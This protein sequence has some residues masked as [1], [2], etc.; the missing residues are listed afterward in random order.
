MFVARHRCLGWNRLGFGL[1]I[2]WISLIT[3]ALAAEDPFAAGVRSTDPL[4]PLEQQQK[5]RLPPGFEIQLV[6]NE[7]AIHKPMNLA[8]DATGRLWVTTSI[9]Y[10]WAAPTNKP[11]RDRLMIFED[12]GPD[13]RARK[14]TQFADGLNIPI[15][16][17]PF[18]TADRR[19]KA[20]VWSIPN[21]WLL[22]DTD[23]DGKADKREVLYGP[24]DYTR[25]THGN[26][27]SFRRGFDGWLY[28]THGYNND[29]HVTARDGSHVDLNSGN[30]YRIR[31]DGSRIEQH[32]HGQ[33]NPFGSAFDPQGNLYTSDCH[34]A[35]IYQLISGG[36]YPSFGKPHDGLGYAPVLM[37]HAHGSTA[38]D[39][40]SY[41]SDEGWHAEYRDNIFIGN[42]MTSR[43]NR[44]RLERIGS[45]PKAIELPD[46][47]T[48]EDSWFR[49][50][51]TCLGP[52]GALYIADFY[53]RIIG[54]YEVPLTHPGRDRERG[55][56]WRV[57]YRGKDSKGLLRDPKL[58]DDLTGLIGELGSESLPRRILAM[59][60]IEDRFGAQ[61]LEPVRA[62]LARPLSATQHA[63]ALWM[64]HR[65][66]QLSVG[67]LERAVATEAVL[68]RIHALRVAT[69]V[70]YRASRKLGSSESLIAAATRM[71]QAGLKDPDPQVQRVASEALA[72]RPHVD[73]VRP[74]LDRLAA[75]PAADTHLVYTLRKAIRDHLLEPTIFQSIL[76]DGA[77]GEG[78]I[79]ALADVAL[80]VRSEAAGSFLLKH[81]GLLESHRGLLSAGLKHAAQFAP[82]SGLEAIAGFAKRQFSG[83]LDFQLDLFKS[84]EQGASQRSI[85]L[86]NSLRRWGTD[87][88]VQAL[89][90]S[91]DSVWYNTPLET[92]TD[93]AN[94]WTFQE[95]LCAD[96]QRV[97]LL[98]SHPLG[99]TLTGRLRSKAFAVPATLSFYLSG[100]DGEPDRAPN[101][102]NV[103]RLRE[104]ATGAV[105]AEAVPP[106]NDT[107]QK[108]VWDLKEQAGKQAVLE[109]VDGDP[110]DAWAWMAFGRFDPPVVELPSRSPGEIAKRQQ[111]AGELA[112]RLRLPVGSQIRQVAMGRE[113]DV[114]ARASAIRA[115]AVLDG[116]SAV[117]ELTPILQDAT[118]PLRLRDAVG[119]ALLG[120]DQESARALV[121]GA[122]K[123]VP[124]RVQNGWA[125]VLATSVS[126]SS[127]LLDAVGSGAVPA[128]ILVERA[129]RDRLSVGKSAA[130]TARFSELTKDL[131]AA[132]RERDRLVRRKRMAYASSKAKPSDGAA[133]FQKNCVVCHQLGGNGALVGPQLTGIGIRGLERLCEDILDPNRNVDVNFRTT[134]LTLRDG[135]TVS[136]L[137]RREEGGQLV[138]ADAAGNEFTVPKNNV[139]ERGQTESSLMPDNF[140]EAI[141][142][143]DFNALLAYLLVQR[144]E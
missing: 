93:A 116:Q 58:P 34:S 54:H 140:G 104:A 3:G 5:F 69:D 100:H 132:D 17:Y 59:G 31:L 87:L 41:C 110:D 23:G 114:E 95:R 8:F 139:K 68:V 50:V 120:A 92:A 45:T 32:T 112:S 6:A 133:V 111:S 103:V 105:L 138:L 27:A 108:I 51:D 66:G 130:L 135:D 70:F 124:Y 16:V 28:C 81:L 57:V 89:S 141:S 12:F 36:W 42:V 9:E 61:A 46:F 96:G 62:A 15:G 75:T 94:P 44:D 126:G 35:P 63:H 137:F 43:L 19:W 47:L 115:F 11:A 109:F 56:L 128:R 71:A 30:T 118:Q 40:L 90:A 117:V 125:E 37:E 18:R 60:E 143:D 82:P 106:R 4:P 26:Q 119:L 84:V 7:P 88:A 131:P 101:G 142:A 80:A 91:P 25:D 53:N 14:V 24:F 74:L 52:D 39:G 83:D 22:E 55:R 129:V 38:I 78:E 127:A 33:V 134:V 64:V 77:W 76:A 113:F 122:M 79:R 107:A 65:L 67:E 13:G 99:E 21:I 10:P 86:D 2:S 72:L 29:S 123:S 73:Q 49:P 85:T 48:T 20:V 98:S 121:L 97:R 144:G 136:G 1:S 102:R